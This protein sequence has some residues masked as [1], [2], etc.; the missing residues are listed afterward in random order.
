M[1]S[2]IFAILFFLVILVIGGLAFYN[3]SLNSSLNSAINEFEDASRTYS[4]VVEGDSSNLVDDADVISDNAKSAVKAGDALASLINLYG[5]DDAP[6]DIVDQINAYYANE[7]FGKQW[8]Y[9]GV[10]DWKFATTYEFVD[11]NVDTL[12]T[13]SDD[14]GLYAYTTATFDSISSLFSNV[15]SYTTDLGIAS[16]PEE[17]QHTDADDD[18]TATTSGDANTSSDESEADDEE[19]VDSITSELEGNDGDGVVSQDSDDLADLAATRE[20]ARLAA[21]GG[22]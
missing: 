9:S 13:C 20:A 2:K 6:D 7:D 22:D 12:F 5:T 3:Q 21:E 11:N 1:G 16:I 10:C 17:Y 4:D 19:S 15:E 14:S 18:A 8:Y